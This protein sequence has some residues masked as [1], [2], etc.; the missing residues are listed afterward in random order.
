[1]IKKEAQQKIRKIKD[2]LT[3]VGKI[4]I[5]TDEDM[6]IFQNNILKDVELEAEEYEFYCPYWDSARNFT[7][8]DDFYI[9]LD[10]EEKDVLTAVNI[11]IGKI[12][13]AYDG[14]FTFP[15]IEDEK[16]I[17]DPEMWSIEE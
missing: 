9:T 6:D 14:S 7:S 16:I 12:E 17:I 11:R 1:M 10:V 3:K 5:E 4:I 8:S 13:R 2:N 15:A